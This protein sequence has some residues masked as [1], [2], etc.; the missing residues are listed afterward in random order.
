MDDFRERK[1]IAEVV[2]DIIGRWLRARGIDGDD[3]AGEQREMGAGVIE[4]RRAA[5]P[6]PRRAAK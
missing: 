6:V 3:I 5:P 1:P 4:G 2:G